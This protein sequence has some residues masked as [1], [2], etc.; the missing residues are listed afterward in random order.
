[1]STSSHDPTDEEF[2]ILWPEPHHTPFNI[3]AGREPAST[4]TP[5]DVTEVRKQKGGFSNLTWGII[6][7]AAV[8]AVI[9][10][11]T[12]IKPV[13]CDGGAGC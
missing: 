8:A 10:G 7:G 5:A 3:S 12:V 6:A 13:L 2:L 1:M 9:V 4:K 11:V